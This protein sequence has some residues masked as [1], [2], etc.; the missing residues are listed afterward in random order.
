MNIALMNRKE[1]MN[2]LDMKEITQGLLHNYELLYK[3][4]NSKSAGKTE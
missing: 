4:N 3:E 2:E 1:L